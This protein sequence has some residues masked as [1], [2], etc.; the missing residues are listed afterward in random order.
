ML[1][2]LLSLYAIAEKRGDGLHPDI[3][4]LLKRRAAAGEIEHI[5]KGVS[6][7]ASPSLD[8]PHGKA[9]EVA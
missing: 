9:S 3:L 5:G 1:S 6:D 8:A 4:A 2:L 7:S